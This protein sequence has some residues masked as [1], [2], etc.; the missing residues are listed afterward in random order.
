MVVLVAGRFRACRR[1]ARCT[2]IFAPPMQP[3]PVQLQTG[4]P[5]PRRRAAQAGVHR[6]QRDAAAQGPRRLRDRHRWCAP[7]AGRP[8]EGW[9]GSFRKGYPVV[10]GKGS[11]PLPPHAPS[12]I[13]APFLGGWHTAAPAGPSVPVFR[14]PSKR[15]PTHKRTTPVPPNNRLVFV[16]RATPRPPKQLLGVCTPHRTAPHPTPPHPAH[17]TPDELL[18]TEMMFDGTFGGLDKHELVALVS[19]LVPVDRSNVSPRRLCAKGGCRGRRRRRRP[20]LP[21]PPPVA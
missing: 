13:R 4:E 2:L 15:C 9:K 7:V 21:P 12:L 1:A 17:P 3:C 20:L 6:R 8:F 18:T 19:C 16:H 5:A 11:P 14:P 10:E